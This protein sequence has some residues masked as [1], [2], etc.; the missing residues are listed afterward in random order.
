MPGFYDEMIVDI[1][2]VDEQLDQVSRGSRS[3]SWRWRLFA[4]TRDVTLRPD[5]RSA[6][7]LAEV[8]FPRARRAV[9][10]AL[11]AL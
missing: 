1:A 10:G 7:S 5:F 2:T 9:V 8:R 4:P 3:A 6:G 11:H